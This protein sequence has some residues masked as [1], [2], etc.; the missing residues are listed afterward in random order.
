[1]L[2]KIELDLK[3]TAEEQKCNLQWLSRAFV[4]LPQLT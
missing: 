2:P 1:M 4:A 3:F